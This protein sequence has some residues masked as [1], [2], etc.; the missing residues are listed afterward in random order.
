MFVAAGEG[1][2]V[3][4]MYGGPGHNSMTYDVSAGQR[5]GHHSGR[6]RL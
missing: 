6:R 1:D 5:P 3:I 2:D 4:K